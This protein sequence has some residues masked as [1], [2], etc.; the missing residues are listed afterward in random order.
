M[1]AGIAA[2][3][4]LLSLT[5]SRVLDGFLLAPLAIATEI[6]VF[7][8]L[9]G[10]AEAIAPHVARYR[11]RSPHGSL[12]TLVAFI[13]FGAVGALV[14]NVL[15]HRAQPTGSGSAADQ[16]VPRVGLPGE[17]SFSIPPAPGGDLSRSRLARV[18]NEF[19][20]HQRQHVPLRYPLGGSLT[21]TTKTSARSL[22][23]STPYETVAGSQDASIN[24]SLV[25]GMSVEAEIEADVAGRAHV[26]IVDV[27]TGQIVAETQPLEGHERVKVR[28]PQGDGV[29]SYRLIFRAAE[30]RDTEVAAKGTI[31]ASPVVVR[32]DPLSVID[33]GP[34][35]IV[36]DSPEQLWKASAPSPFDIDWDD[37]GASLALA[38]VRVTVYSPRGETSARVGIRLRD[39]D[40]GTAAVSEA[41]VE[42]P[43]V[44]TFAWLTRVSREVPPTTGDV[45]VTL[46]RGIGRRRYVLEIGSTAPGISV[47]IVGKLA[48]YR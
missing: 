44:G 37:V 35:T 5:L 1:G 23:R 3:S 10:C 47:S 6:G 26:G 14:W 4:Y 45:D 11:E 31:T 21:A 17:S 36:F 28:L 18:I 8:V 15:I 24:W 27:A 9:A 25:T 42:A 19:N 46:V 32:E 29:K 22:V 48:L 12:M 38:S 7:F 13:V 20:Q 16:P 34:S 2:G 30:E 43:R 33:V 41:S 39:L 40:S